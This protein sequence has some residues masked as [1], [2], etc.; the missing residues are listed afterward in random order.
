MTLEALGV[1]GLSLSN[2]DQRYSSNAGL[3]S[4]PHSCPSCVVGQPANEGPH[5]SSNDSFSMKKILV[6]LLATF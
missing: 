5:S 2:N 1:G 4:T 3:G 6:R